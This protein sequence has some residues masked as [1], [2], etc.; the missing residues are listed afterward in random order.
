MKTLAVG[1]T[2]NWVK[3]LGH[4]TEEKFV[5]RILSKASGNS[6][7]G[8]VVVGSTISLAF[9]VAADGLAV[10]GLADTDEG[11]VANVGEAAGELAAESIA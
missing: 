9:A 10:D 4:E 3:K 2:Y 11:K 7:L 8:S 1:M 6:Q 5:L